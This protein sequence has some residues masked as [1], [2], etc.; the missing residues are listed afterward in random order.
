MISLMLF[1]MAFL[2]LGMLIIMGVAVGW[3]LLPIVIIVVLGKKFIQALTKLIEAIKMKKGEVVVMSR[4]ELE[5]N[6]E[7]KKKD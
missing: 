1:L 6:Y 4:S 7:P 3:W 2:A 5:K